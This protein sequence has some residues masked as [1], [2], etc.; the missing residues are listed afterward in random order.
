MALGLPELTI[1]NF[2]YI[3]LFLIFLIIGLRGLEF[4]K[5]GA[6]KAKDYD[7]YEPYL[8]KWLMDNNLGAFVPLMSLIGVSQY[9]APKSST[10]GI[11]IIIISTL[12][13][14]FFTFIA[15]LWY[16][17][18]GFLLI[19]I[20]SV[21]A[22][23]YIDT[24][25]SYSCLN[26]GKLNVFDQYGSGSVLMVFFAA[27]CI[28]IFS[29]GGRVGICIGAFLHIIKVIGLILLDYYVTFKKHPA[30]S[31]LCLSIFH[32]SFA[33]LIGFTISLLMLGFAYG[34][35]LSTNQFVSL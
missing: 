1:Y 24:L 27:A 8:V 6:I 2:P 14:I 5:S 3:T 23:T 13:L 32:H 33:Y 17:H 16:G 25:Q 18:I 29:S 21:M 4:A 7:T 12:I 30:Q 35:V 26:G 9:S 20:V 19:F 22:G 34:V 11:G 31:R 28:N 15:E 10:G